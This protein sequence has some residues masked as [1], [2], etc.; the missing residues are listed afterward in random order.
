MFLVCLLQIWKH[1]SWLIWSYTSRWVVCLFFFS[2]C[3]CVFFFI[4][5]HFGSPA[6]KG[7]PCLSS[8]VGVLQS[9]FC[10]AAFVISEESLFF[11]CSGIWLCRGLFFLLAKL[12]EPWW[13][14]ETPVGG[15]AARS[16]NSS[17]WNPAQP[18]DSS[19]IG[20]RCE[21][22]RWASSAAAYKPDSVLEWILRFLLSVPNFLLGAEQQA[23]GSPLQ[24]VSVSHWVVWF[25]KL[26]F[27]VQFRSV[28]TNLDLKKKQQ[29]KC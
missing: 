28:K 13:D 11:F 19:L 2:F 16:D 15:G 26:R 29:K 10:V 3:V 23:L 1:Y 7:W 20:Q 25:T 17:V 27:F 21:T 8:Q 4:M 24:A 18:T 6:D 9:R 12:C 5:I 22:R 14:G